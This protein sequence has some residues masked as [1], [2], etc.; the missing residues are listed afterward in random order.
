MGHMRMAKSN[1]GSDSDVEMT[2][3][4]HDPWKTS[5]L[6]NVLTAAAAVSA[7]PKLYGK[8]GWPMWGDAMML[9]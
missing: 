8:F 9:A 2:L 6:E 7:T 1:H 3:L 4:M 5:I